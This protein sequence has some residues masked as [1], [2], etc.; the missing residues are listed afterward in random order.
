MRYFILFVFSIFFVSTSYADTLQKALDEARIKNDVSAMQMTILM[1]GK[2]P[3]HVVS[4]TTMKAK[5]SPSIT[6]D[7]LFQIGSDTKSFTSALILKLSLEGKLKLSDKITQYFPEYKLWK[8]VTIWQILHNNSGIPSYSKIKPFQKKL[9]ANPN[10]IWTPSELLG[11]VAK[12]KLEFKPGHGW[13]YSNSNFILAG[14]IAEKV[15]NKSLKDLY[16]EYFF[17]KLN[18]QNTYYSIHPYPTEIL[19]RMAH[20]Y[21]E[22]NRDVTADNLSWGASA[23]AIVSNT[24]DLATWAHALFHGKVVPES[25]LKEM[26]TV[27]STKTG[28]TEKNPKEGYGMAVGTRINK[29]YGRWWGHEGE[30]LGYHAIFVWYPEHDITI[31]ILTNGQA[32]HLL[33]FATS[34]P[35]LVGIKAKK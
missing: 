32:P 13:D 10:Y 28:L 6:P 25:A 29:N 12:K 5:K 14:M 4:G 26:M 17:D 16:E 23:G 21:S 11:A 9:F 3:L 24:T 20:G 35:G 31:A 22:K 30:T 1:P 33:D 19:N 2:E 34:V 8:D 27:V 15:T 7:T 18:L